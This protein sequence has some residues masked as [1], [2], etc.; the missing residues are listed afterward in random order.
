MIK[1][2]IHDKISY[3]FLS[4]AATKADLPPP[5]PEEND[6]CLLMPLLALP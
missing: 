4:L 5:I 2:I 6:P 3:S 1:L